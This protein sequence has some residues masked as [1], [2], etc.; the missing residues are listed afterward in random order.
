M[1]LR[2]KR[3]YPDP[4]LSICSQSESKPILESKRRKSE[5]LQK[6]AAKYVLYSF[7]MRDFK[8]G[9][10]EIPDYII[11]CICL[12][13]AEYDGYK[14]HKVKDIVTEICR[15][16]SVN[17]SSGDSRLLLRSKVSMLTFA[18]RSKIPIKCLK[19]SDV[20]EK[21][22]EKALILKA[23]V[24]LGVLNTLRAIEVNRWDQKLIEQDYKD[25]IKFII[26]NEKVEVARL[27]F[28][29]PPV[30]VK[31]EKDLNNLQSRNIS[32]EWIIGEHLIHTL[33]V[34]TGEWMMEFRLP[35]RMS[36]KSSSLKPISGDSDSFSSN[37]SLVVELLPSNLKLLKPAKLT[38]PHCL[39]LKKGCEWKA[40]YIAAIMKKV[41]LNVVNHLIMRHKSRT[42]GLLKGN[43]PL[44]EPQPDTP[45]LLNEGN[46]IIELRT[47]SWE[48]FD[49]GDEIVEG[50]RI[51]LYAA[52][53]LTSHKAKVHIDIGYYLDLV[54][55]EE[56][57][58]LHEG[59]TNMWLHLRYT[60]HQS[61]YLTGHFHTFVF[62]KKGTLETNECS[63]YFKAGQE[64]DLT[65]L[66]FGLEDGEA[67]S[68]AS[69]S[70]K[71]VDAGLSQSQK[72]TGDESQTVK[73]P[74]ANIDPQVRTESLRNPSL[75]SHQATRGEAEGNP[76]GTEA[77]TK[78]SKVVNDSTLWDLSENLS[79]EWRH[80][81]RKLK[82]T[83]TDLRN[84]EA[85]NKSNGQ[86]EVVYQM[87]LLWKRKRG[88]AAT[89]K[90]LRDALKAA[91]L[92][93]LHDNFL[94]W[95]KFGTT[96]VHR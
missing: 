12:C 51:V 16:E 87:L 67:D 49:I 33:N 70:D 34:T 62:N 48:K 11:N 81:G 46:C 39:V 94:K 15:R 91:G 9:D 3:G 64:S 31:D 77:M 37:S 19:L 56:S 25:L 53:H 93:D 14:G 45:Y 66:T 76:A 60:I 17:F 4:D 74:L 71:V 27:L 83:E 29:R 89:N 21:I 38:L 78:D 96:S 65:D 5:P 68:A 8:T 36:A 79:K 58:N 35:G 23:D 75:P 47:F 2:E 7:L 10:G 88:M 6:K 84:I 18:S 55:G 32:V 57:K 41:N 69:S 20:V 52:K 44:W 80:V 28:P 92:M 63:C 90:T 85:D 59:L 40:K 22:T 30:A 43:H 82:L 95:G 26:N 86:K 72:K 61:S 42:E 1:L 50:K 54:G 73:Q 24:S 13:F